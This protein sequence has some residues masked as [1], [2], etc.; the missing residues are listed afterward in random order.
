[1]SSQE[2]E[3]F[4]DLEDMEVNNFAHIPDWEVARLAKNR[5]LAKELAPRGSNFFL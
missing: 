3:I 4:Q 2:I 1:M 5:A